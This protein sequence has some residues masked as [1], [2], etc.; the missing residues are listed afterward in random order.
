[1]VLEGYYPC[2]C[3]CTMIVVCYNHGFE[4]EDE[5]IHGHTYACAYGLFSGCVGGEHDKTISCGFSVCVALKADGTAEAWG[6][7]DK[8]GD[9]SG[10]KLVDVVDIMHEVRMISA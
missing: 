4:Y 3:C 9:A 10:V 8:G 7:A 1:M 5:R 6:D 2:V